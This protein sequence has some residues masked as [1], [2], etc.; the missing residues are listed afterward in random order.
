MVIPHVVAFVCFSAKMW[1]RVTFAV[2]AA[3]TFI[4]NQGDLD[5]LRPKACQMVEDKKEESTDKDKD[6]EK[7]KEVLSPETLAR[8]RRHGKDPGAVDVDGD[9]IDTDRKCF[10][11]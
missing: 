2:R 7:E 9:V 5:A 8:K 11:L 10:D 6:K 1:Q 4:E 3:T